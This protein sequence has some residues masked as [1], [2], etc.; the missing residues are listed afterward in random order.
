MDETIRSFKISAW[1]RTVETAGC[2]IGA[3]RTLREINKKSG[4]PLFSLLDVSVTSPD[5]KPLPNIVFIRGHAVVVVPLLVNEATGEERFL[6]VR[7]HRV[8]NGML[9][10]EFPAGMLDHENDTPVAVARKELYEETGLSVGE[11]QLIPLSP[12][13]L[14]SSAGA[15]DEAVYYYGCKI[16]L[17]DRDFRGLENSYRENSSEHEF[18]TVAL[19]TRS[20]AE[21]QINSIQAMLGFN[22]FYS[23]FA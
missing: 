10:L 1:K 16:K 13:P 22:L 21:P 7:Q 20:E 9:T 6:M 23:K 17:Q 12:T 4:A 14:Y 5:G 11:Q 3:I 18:I 19:L 8:G 15:S 2:M